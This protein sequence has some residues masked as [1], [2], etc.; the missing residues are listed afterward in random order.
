MQNLLSY[1]GN[2]SEY[3]A[4]Y[5]ILIC[6]RKFGEAQFT[7]HPSW[8]SSSF[9]CRNHVGWKWPSRVREGWLLGRRDVNGDPI[10]DFPWGIP[11]L[12][13]VWESKNLRE[14]KGLKLSLYSIL[15]KK[16]ILAPSIFSGYVA[17]KL[18][19]MRWGSRINF[20]HGI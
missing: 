4:C 14:L 8:T 15:N 19:L 10:P 1:L 13:L 11:P 5:K 18:A 17:P 6:T 2:R 3:W 12:G 9:E 7:F 20:L 16:W